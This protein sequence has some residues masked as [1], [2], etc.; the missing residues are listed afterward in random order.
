MGTTAPMAA[1]RTALVA[2]DRCP[3][4]PLLLLVVLPLVAVPEVIPS[5]SASR[6]RRWRPPVARP[7]FLPS[8]WPSFALRASADFPRFSMSALP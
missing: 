6:V 4:P 3:P 5:S 8:R 7:P 1:A 2:A